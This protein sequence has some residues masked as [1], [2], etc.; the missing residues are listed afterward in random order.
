MHSAFCK[1]RL[2]FRFTAITSR[3]RMRVKD[4]YFIKI[5]DKDSSCFGIGE[6]AVFKGLSSDDIPD[7]EEILRKVCGDIDRY[8]SAPEL[9]NSYPS[10]K[11]GIETAIR[12]LRNGGRRLIFLSGWTSGDA[13]I[14]INGLVWMGDKSLMGNRIRKKADEGFNC[15]KI[16]I[17][18]IDFNDELDLLRLVR[19]LCPEVQLRLDANGAFSPDDA[20]TKLSKLSEFGIHSIEQP[21]RQGQ[22]DAM[23]YLCRNSPIPIALDEELI[24]LNDTDSKIKM[25][26]SIHPHYLILKPTLCGGF[27]GSDEWIQLASE[28]NIRWWATSALESNIG[29]NAIAQWVS[30]KSSEIPQGLGTGQL[31]YNNIPSPLTLCGENLWYNEKEGWEMPELE[32]IEC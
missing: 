27:H 15:I 1:Y 4:T 11:M 16:K 6:A 2:D 18:G 8:V 7:Y 30:T 25:L 26:D 14:V 12:D 31:Y 19:R 20:M 17:G 9:L 23:E 5:W 10:I 28:R 22:W 13:P 29:L 3:D 21:I 32:W 24:G